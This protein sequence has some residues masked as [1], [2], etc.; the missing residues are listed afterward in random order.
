MRGLWVPQFSSSAQAGL[1]VSHRHRSRSG[2]AAHARALQ[3]LILAA[4]APGGSRPHPDSRGLSSARR[5]CAGSSGVSRG[6][7]GSPAGLFRQLE[8]LPNSNW[9]QRWRERRPGGTATTPVPRTWIRADI[10]WS[11]FP[12]PLPWPGSPSTTW[13]HCGYLAAAATWTASMPAQSRSSAPVPEPGMARTATSSEESGPYPGLVQ[14]Q[15]R[16]NRGEN[17]CAGRR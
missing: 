8:L 3:D 15:P 5:R 17:N 2:R 10:T 1:R 7:Q 13:C 12:R 11:R 14:V 4:D 16:K 9:C 6:Y